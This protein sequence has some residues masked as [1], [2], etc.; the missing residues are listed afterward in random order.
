MKQKIFILSIFA[1]FIVSCT[2][3]NNNWKVAQEKGTVE[4]YQSYIENNPQAENIELANKIID[5][6]LSDK[7]KQTEPEVWEK[8]KEANTV[9]AYKKYL[10]TYNTNN[11][12]LYVFEAFKNIFYLENAEFVQKYKIIIDFFQDM[13]K[14][15]P[16]SDLFT[17]YFD[18]NK[19]LYNKDKLKA[20]YSYKRF[21]EDDSFNLYQDALYLEGC[22]YDYIIYPGWD[23]NIKETPNIITFTYE[24][25]VSGIFYYFKWELKNDK[26]VITEMEVWVKGD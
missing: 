7:T 16:Y 26:F 24:P 2:N 11:D 18:E 17:K 3:T 10:D 5:S 8:A 15:E 22:L 4:A 12:A 6:L 9:E 13:A 19:C 23:I 20:P 14:A 25:M 1:V 21:E